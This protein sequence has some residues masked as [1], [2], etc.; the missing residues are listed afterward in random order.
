MNVGCL[1][2]AG[3]SLDFQMSCCEFTLSDLTSKRAD[4][5]GFFSVLLRW[6]HAVAGA[7]N[8]REQPP[9]Q[10]STSLLLSASLGIVDDG[11][12]EPAETR[13]NGD[14]QA[15]LGSPVRVESSAVL[16]GSS[17]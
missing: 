12:S 10:R 9:G 17:A 5:P 6:N 2:Q 7:E 11:T 3:E 15:D 8:C 16:K 13:P 14:V 4:R 1:S